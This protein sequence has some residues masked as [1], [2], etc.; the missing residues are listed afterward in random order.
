MQAFV[1]CFPFGAEELLLAR[2]LFVKRNPENGGAFLIFSI[3]PVGYN[4][5]TGGGKC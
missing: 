1:F 3:F 5:A 4:V 2:F